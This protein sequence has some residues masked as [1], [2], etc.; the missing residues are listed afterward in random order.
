MQH[1]DAT[2]VGNVCSETIGTGDRYWS[3]KQ[4]ARPLVVQ[5]NVFILTPPNF[6]AIILKK[7][8]L[9][10][11][12]AILALSISHLNCCHDVG[13]SPPLLALLILLLSHDFSY[14]LEQFVK[15]IVATV[16]TIPCQQE[17]DVLAS[18]LQFGSKIQW[19][20]NTEGKSWCVLAFFEFEI[21]RFQR[22]YTVQ[23]N[24]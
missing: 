3:P 14:P 4:G 7:I 1:H 5:I 21:G 16:R 12:N 13:L 23:Y 19:D 22:N 6:Y 9:I 11:I 18:I 20:W 8:F 10:Y 17:I 15:S 24:F 2:S